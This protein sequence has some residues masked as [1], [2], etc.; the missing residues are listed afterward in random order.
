MLRTRLTA[1]AQPQVGS[2]HVGDRPPPPDD[3]AG[4]RH[5]TLASHLLRERHERVGP[6]FS[7]L[8]NRGGDPSRLY[9]GPFA[10]GGAGECGVCASEGSRRTDPPRRAHVARRGRSRRTRRSPP[11]PPR[12]VPSASNLKASACEKREMREKGMGEERAGRLTATGASPAA[13]QP[14]ESVPQV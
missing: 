5:A 9:P 4:R 1:G 11:R 10:G 2:L 8:Q 7:G 14:G 6:S 13:A 12:P 3:D